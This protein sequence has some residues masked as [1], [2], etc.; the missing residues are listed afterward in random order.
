M[1]YIKDPEFQLENTAVALG[2]FEGLHLGHQL[3]FD[4]IKRRKDM[5]QKSV[6]FTF[7]M[8]PRSALSGDTSYQ[9]IYTKEERRILLE[10]FDIDILI[11]HPFTKEFAALGPEDFVR[12]VLVGKAGAKTVVVGRDFH[13]GRK[14]AGNVGVLEDL[15]PKYGYQLVVIEKM[16][17]DGQDVS[18]T[19]I[20]EHLKKGEM[21]AAETLLGRPYTIAGPVVH[22]KALG[23]TIQIPTANQ[24]ADKNKL[25]PPNGVYVSRIFVQGEEKPY[26]GITN[27]GVKPTVE[28]R[29]V[30]GVETNI[31]GFD[32]D[33]Y[34]EVIEVELLHYRRPEMHF[35]S[36]EDLKR[37]MEADIAFA[38]H[39]AE[40]QR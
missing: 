40:G 32:R 39:W 25:I 26:Y 29:A 28:Q 11:E 22:G 21:E 5:G 3:L 1:E 10:D 24:I 13:F 14:R 20:R 16:Q 12:D 31:F 4:E 30:K 36:V 9:Q 37:Q 38:Y 15:A 2:K 7:D 33:I 35:S 34:D 17:M 8:P 23:R 19:R 27:V 6:V 18:S